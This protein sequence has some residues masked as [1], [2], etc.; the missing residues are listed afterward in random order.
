VP[1]IAWGGDDNESPFV[2]AGIGSGLRRSALE[3]V[4]ARIEEFY[5]QV[6]AEPIE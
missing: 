3:A 2:G 1:S 6:P 4:I 5:E